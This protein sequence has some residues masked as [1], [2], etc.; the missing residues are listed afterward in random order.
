MD[1]PTTQLQL[2]HHFLSFFLPEAMLDFFELVWMETEPLTSMESKK[3][4]L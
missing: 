2:Y 3:D 1:K 4:I